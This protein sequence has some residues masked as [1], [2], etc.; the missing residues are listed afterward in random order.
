MERE[1]AHSSYDSNCPR[2]DIL[3]HLAA[4]SEELA[5]SLSTLIMQGHEGCNCVN[6][7]DPCEN[8]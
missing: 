2:G 5:R 7:F 3:V 8:K 6:R 4:R 1:H